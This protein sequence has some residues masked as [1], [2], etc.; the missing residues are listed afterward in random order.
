MKKTLK[1]NLINDIISLRI[2]QRTQGGVFGQVEI[3]KS[4]EFGRTADKSFCSKQINCKLVFIEDDGGMK[5]II[6]LS[7]KIKHFE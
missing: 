2:M 7:K 3:P 6:L 5:I 1:S 4:P